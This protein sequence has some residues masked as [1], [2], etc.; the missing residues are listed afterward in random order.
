MILSADSKNSAPQLGRITVG[1]VIYAFHDGGMERGLLNL[2]NYGDRDRFHHIILCLTEAGAFTRLLASPSCTV[3][4]LHKKEGN[5]WRLPWRIAQVARQHMIDILHA[6]GWP[7]MVE[8]IIGAW[9]A[10]V[11]A[12]IYT[13]HGKTFNELQGVNFQRRWVQRI[14]I[15]CFN[16]VMTLNRS[17]RSDLSAECL[18][19]EDFIQII[20]NGVDIDIF[21]PQQERLS[22]R[23]A[24]NLPKDRLI[25]GNVARLDPVKNHEVILRALSRV[26]KALRP[27]F[28]LVGDG[29][30]RIALQ[31]QIYELGLDSDVCL[32]GYSNH[33]SELLNCMDFYVQSSLYEGFSNTVLEALAC[34]L[35]VL[36]TKV[37]GTMDIL[38]EN[39]E[40]FFFQPTD[41]EMLAFLFVRLVRD[42]ELRCV[43]GEQ[44]RRRAAQYFPV[45]SMVHKYEAIYRDLVEENGSSRNL[46]ADCISL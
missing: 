34:G 42:Q 9:L 22:L 32:F 43:L 26:E 2:I 29:A 31:R 3:I 24:F 28:L 19:P 33:I 30:H 15:R 4:E 35:P 38:T 27:F 11:S 7:A 21:R 37:G 13:F 17:M 45:Q 6:R 18:L 23:A 5:D 12:T 36:A 16:R 46:E 40:G 44:A 39:K 14:M 10:D 8:T 20:A 25:V 1:H 41:D